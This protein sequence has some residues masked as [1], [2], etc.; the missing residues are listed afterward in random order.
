MYGGYSRSTGI[1]KKRS[2]HE[3]E[4]GTILSYCATGTSSPDSLLSWI[5]ILESYNPNMKNLQVVFR[6]H[7][8]TKELGTIDND[9]PP[10]P[11]DPDSPEGGGE[12]TKRRPSED[13]HKKDNI[14]AEVVGK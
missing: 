11:T 2:L 5:R 13:H 4:D 12:G 9:L 7:S 6:L 14:E 3:Q 1:A 8:P 10:V